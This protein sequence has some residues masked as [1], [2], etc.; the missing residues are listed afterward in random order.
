MDFRQ[1]LTKRIVIVFAL[2]SAFVAGVF[3][4]G[5][6]ATVH[7]VE[8]K[9]TSADLGGGLNRL[10]HQ[11]DTAAWNHRPGKDELFFAQGESG[12]MAIDPALA[13]LRKV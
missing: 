7:I 6:L 10:L 4:A 13:T 12:D 3:A 2:M 1:S 9:F 8:Y 11:H 5:I